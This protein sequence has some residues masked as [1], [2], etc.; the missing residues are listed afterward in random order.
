MPCIFVVNLWDDDA[1]DNLSALVDLMDS[2][3]K[4]EVRENSEG[5]SQA[6]PLV[7]A[8]D[9]PDNPVKTSQTMPVAVPLDPHNPPCKCHPAKPSLR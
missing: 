2:F 1:E 8:L 5:T 7:V 6:M 9:D 3:D 4:G